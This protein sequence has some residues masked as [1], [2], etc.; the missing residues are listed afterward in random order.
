MQTISRAALDTHK[1]ESTLVVASHGYILRVHN[2]CTLF[3]NVMM[4]K[5]REE[6]DFCC[7]CCGYGWQCEDHDQ[8]NPRHYLKNVLVTWT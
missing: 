5:G 8:K 7:C 6:E 4:T 1:I 2:E 3:N